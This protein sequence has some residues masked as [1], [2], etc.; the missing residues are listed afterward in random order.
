MKVKPKTVGWC[1]VLPAAIEELFRGGVAYIR[2]SESLEGL[3]GDNE[4]ETT[5]IEIIKR[6]IEEPFRQIVANAGKEGAV[7]VQKLRWLV[8]MPRTDVYEK[9]ACCRCGRSC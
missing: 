7:V 1:I 5:G 2:A 3:K 4:D 9:L 8:T 6:A